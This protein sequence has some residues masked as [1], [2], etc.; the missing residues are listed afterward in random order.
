MDIKTKRRVQVPKE[1]LDKIKK[2]GDKKEI[3]ESIWQ[4]IKKAGDKK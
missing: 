3:P 1:I 2:I 4:S